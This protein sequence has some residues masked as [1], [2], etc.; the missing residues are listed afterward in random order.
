MK[1]ILLLLS[2][3]GIL[4][5]SYAVFGLDFLIFLTSLSF[6]ED[7]KIKIKNIKNK[8]FKW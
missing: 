8:Y 4:E 6:I 5:S 1:S 3:R 2:M 7:D